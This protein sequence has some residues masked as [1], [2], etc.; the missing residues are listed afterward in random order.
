MTASFGRNSW[1][2]ALAMRIS[3]IV[4]STRPSVIDD[5]GEDKDAAQHD[6]DR[7]PFPA[8]QRRTLEPQRPQ[9]QDGAEDDH[10]NAKDARE[11]ARPHPCGGAERVVGRDDDRRD[12]NGD[13]HQPGDEILR[14][15]H[16]SHWCLPVFGTDYNPLFGA[17]LFEIAVEILALHALLELRLHFIEGRDLRVPNVR[18][19]DHVPAELRLHRRA[20]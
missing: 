6:D 16:N 9:R 2:A 13:E 1:L 14:A 20:R 5:E 18:D 11:V 10:Q 15:A 12:T 8:G 7:P 19:F 3:R 4:D 17:E